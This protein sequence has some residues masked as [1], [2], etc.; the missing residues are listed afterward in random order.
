LRK[1]WIFLFLWLLIGITFLTLG[2]LDTIYRLEVAVGYINRAQSAGFAEEMMNYLSEALKILPSSGNP[3]WLFPTTRTD[4]SL[5]Y[6]DLTSIEDRLLIISNTA[7]DSPAYAQTLNDI[8][9]KLSVI[10][11]QIGEAMPYTLITPVNILLALVWLLTPYI[12][13][14]VINMMYNNR[15]RKI[16]G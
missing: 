3:V 9:G 11:G 16:G 7:K 12:T 4:F 5:I 10:I 15:S 1:L 14:K 13:Y 8:R 2:Y 6:S